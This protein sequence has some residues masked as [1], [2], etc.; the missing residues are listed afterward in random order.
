MRVDKVLIF[1]RSINHAERKASGIELVE[2]YGA[3]GLIE[4]RSKV[5]RICRRLDKERSPRRKRK[6]TRHH[7]RK[8]ACSKK[9]R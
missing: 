2:D 7:R 8:R 3:N 5:E 4:D 1:V 6:M 9:C